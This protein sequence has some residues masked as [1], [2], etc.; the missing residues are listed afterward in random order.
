LLR[1]LG[2][3]LNHPHGKKDR[4]KKRNPK[5]T[6]RK[7]IAGRQRQPERDTKGV[8]EK[9]KRKTMC[10]PLTKEGGNPE[11]KISAGRR[12]TS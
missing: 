2:G 8:S 1:E 4:G 5:K 9:G 3:E 6:P 12:P 7:D 10:N 11:V